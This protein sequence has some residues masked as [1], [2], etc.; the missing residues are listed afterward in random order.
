MRAH[1]LARLHIV[2]S[3]VNLEEML[4]E[5]I[6]QD[7]DISVL[8]IRALVQVLTAELTKASRLSALK[9]LYELL[10][11][12]QSEIALVNGYV[13]LLCGHGLALL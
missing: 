9:R 1:D 8:E 6:R 10:D 2:A 3:V 5:M 4:T 13:E 7:Q 11:R 12:N